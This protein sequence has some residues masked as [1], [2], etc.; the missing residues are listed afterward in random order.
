MATCPD[1][2][3][4]LSDDHWC[5]ARRW[6]AVRTAIFT[7]SGVLFGAI[8][9]LVLVDDP[10]AWLAIAAGLVGGLVSLAVWRAVGF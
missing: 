8:T 2:G 9:V 1:C 4:S 10:S 7:V 5:S 3:G 6:R